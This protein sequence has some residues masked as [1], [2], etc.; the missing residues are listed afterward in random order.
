MTAGNIAVVVSGHFTAYDSATVRASDSATVRAFA[1]VF[2]RLFSAIKITA[3]A[4]VVVMREP[5]A[6]GLIEGGHVVDTTA[7]KDAAEWCEEH[8]VEVNDG[9]AILYKGLDDKFVSAH[10]TSYAPGSVPIAD[11]WDGG[12]RECGGGLHFSPAP[13]MTLE[14]ASA[15]ARFVACPVALSDIRPPQPGDT[16]PGKVKAKGCCAPVYEVDI[17]GRVTAPA[18]E[19]A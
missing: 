8:G 14:F 19:A 13:A 2:V 5:G 1:R 9:V 3:T 17:H 15:A 11:D 10:G 12:K 18:R 7:P 6:S 16:Y 4:Q